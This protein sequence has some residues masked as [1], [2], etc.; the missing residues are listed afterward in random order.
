[1][2]GNIGFSE[3]LVIAVVGLLVFGP[4]RLPRAVAD[5]ARMVRQLR[6][7]TRE[8]MVEVKGELGPEFADLD[9][10]SLHP[11]RLVSDHLLDDQ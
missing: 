5:A 8:A 3:L 4:H 6:R 7:M 11:H 2:F 9:L 1:M 10:A